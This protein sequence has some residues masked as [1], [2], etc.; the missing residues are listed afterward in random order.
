MGL[1]CG[2]STPQPETRLINDDQR[3]RLHVA[4]GGKALVLVSQVSIAALNVWRSPVLSR[5]S[6]AESYT[7]LG[8]LHSRWLSG[9][10][11]LSDP[12]NV[13]FHTHGSAQEPKQGPA[14]P[15]VLSC[16]A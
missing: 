7:S 16:C 9:E 12:V 10:V 11:A 2:A 14:G 1:S 6:A 4:A 15:W 3:T 5:P 8:A 13:E